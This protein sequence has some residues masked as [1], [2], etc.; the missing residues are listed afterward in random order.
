MEHKKEVTAESWTDLMNILAEDAKHF[1]GIS[2]HRN[3]KA[4]RGMADASW[5]ITTGLQR[6]NKNAFIQVEKHLF[7]NFQKY[8]PQNSVIF[9][10]FWN[11]LTLA[12]HH[13]LPTRLL[14]WS[15]SPLVALHFALDNYELFDNGSEAVIWSVD[16]EALKHTL[17]DENNIRES[18]IKEG[19]ITFT[20]ETL[21]RMWSSFDELSSEAVDDFMI[22]FEP[23][24]F[25]N[26]LINQYALLSTTRNPKT[27][28]SDWLQM[29]GDLYRRIIIP[30]KLKWEF[31]DRLDQ[32][33]IT[34]RIIY[35]GLDG[36]CLW[37]KRWYCSK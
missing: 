16:L 22:F 6:V 23:P 30:N 2:R 20:I 7:R 12:E 14:D 9:N 28:V 17:P 8:A 32:I 1:E 25:N 13:G 15:Y 36:L 18:F 4:Y 29:H 34:E 3:E 21:D 10:T 27:V 31:R 33:N 37:L 24:S 26:R 19:A 5:P 35:P 11:W